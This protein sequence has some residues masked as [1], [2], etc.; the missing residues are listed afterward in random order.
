M[1]PYFALRLSLKGALAARTGNF[2]LAVSPR[3]ADGLMAMRTAEIFVL[4]ITGVFLDQREAGTNWPGQF[5]VF[6]VF[7]LPFPDV[8]GKGTEQGEENQSI[9]QLIQKGTAQRQH[10]DQHDS[11]R[12]EQQ[13]IVQRIR[14]ITSGHKPVKRVF[15]FIKHG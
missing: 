2:N 7:L 15:N 11:D 9:G 3:H 4:L 8:A 12:R 5:H 6:D 1:I 14:S 10:V 13:K